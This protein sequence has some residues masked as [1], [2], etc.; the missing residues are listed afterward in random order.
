M[1]HAWFLANL[2]QGLVPAGSLGS[3]EVTIEGVESFHD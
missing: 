1:H 3:L 2:F